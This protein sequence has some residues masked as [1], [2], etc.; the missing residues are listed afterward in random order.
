VDADGRVWVG[1]AKGLALYDPKTDSWRRWRTERGK[2]LSD[3][4]NDVYCAPD[5]SVW[6]ATDQGASK[7]FRDQ[8]WSVRGTDGLVSNRVRVLV[9]DLAGNGLWFGT[10]AGASHLKL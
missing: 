9:P 6:I 5:G 7:L 4:V 3:M 1:T 10:A 8:W 2:L